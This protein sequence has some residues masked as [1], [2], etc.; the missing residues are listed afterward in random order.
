MSSPI[1][2][3]KDLDAALMYAP[4]WVRKQTEPMRRPAAPTVGRALRRRVSHDQPFSG[5]LAMAK[6]QH[7][8]ALDPDKIPEPPIDDA[9]SL[10]PMVLRLCGVAAVAGVVAWFLIS[11][12][13]IGLLRDAVM[14]A[15]APTPVA[16]NDT[17]PNPLRSAAAVGL[18]VQHGLAQ[19]N[20]HPSPPEAPLPVAAIQPTPVVAVSPAPAAAESGSLPADKNLSLDQDEI[21]MLLKR[22]KDFLTNGDF[23]SARLLLRRAAEAGSADAA[24]ALGASFDPLVIRRLGAIGADPDA[25]RA[26]KWYQKAVDLGSDA[27]SQQLAKLAVAP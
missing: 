25:A 23:S 10:W 6:L 8:L 24:L 17:T 2:H 16:V 1:H 27:A 18:L 21:A 12:P 3:A 4:P 11:A 15:D 13:S 20:E 19:V 7:Q 14:R 9:R 22:G 5:D 26:R